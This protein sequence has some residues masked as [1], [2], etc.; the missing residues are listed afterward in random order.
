MPAGPF[1]AKALVR[2]L[3]LATLA[4][5]C[6]EGFARAM[7]DPAAEVVLQD[8]SPSS[9]DGQ[10]NDLAQV[11]V[12]LT[13][14][15]SSDS[16]PDEGATPGME[17]EQAALPE[18]KQRRPGTFVRWVLFLWT[19]LLLLSDPQLAVCQPLP[20]PAGPPPGPI[21]PALPLL[22]APQS[23]TLVAPPTFQWLPAQVLQPFNAKDQAKATAAL[24]AALVQ[25]LQVPLP[26]SNATQLLANL[27]GARVAT[28]APYSLPL[29]APNNANGTVAPTD[30]E[31]AT[32]ALFQTAR[33]IQNNVLD[34]GTGGGP[35]NS[36]SAQI[37]TQLSSIQDQLNNALALRSNSQPNTS[38]ALSNGLW[39]ALASFS[40]IASAALSTPTDLNN[41]ALVAGTASEIDETIT[42]FINLYLITELRLPAI[43]LNLERFANFSRRSEKN[44]ENSG[45]GPPSIEFERAECLNCTKSCNFE[46]NSYQY[47]TAVYGEEGTTINLLAYAYFFIKGVQLAA[48]DAAILANV[49]ASSS[50]N[51]TN[52]SNCS[53]TGGP[54]PARR[55]LQANSMELGN[56]TVGTDANATLPSGPGP[57]FP[58]P[59][60]RYTSLQ[61]QNL[62]PLLP[63]DT[64]S[65]P[66]VMNRLGINGYTPYD[67]GCTQCCFLDVNKP[68]LAAARIAVITAW[69]NAIGAG[70]FGLRVDLATQAFLETLDPVQGP[71]VLA[72]I[73]SNA[74]QYF[75]E[76]FEGATPPSPGSGD[77]GALPDLAVLQA[78]MA[79]V[80][81]AVGSS[82]APPAPALLSGIL[83]TAMQNRQASR[84][85]TNTNLTDT[86][87]YGLQILANMAAQMPSAVTVKVVTGSLNLAQQW[88]ADTGYLLRLLSN[89]VGIE[90]NQIATARASKVLLDYAN[91]QTTNSV[92]QDPDNPLCGSKKC[93]RECN[94]LNFQIQYGSVDIRLVAAQIGGVAYTLAITANFMNL[95]MDANQIINAIIAQLNTAPPAKMAANHLSGMPFGMRFYAKSAPA[96]SADSFAGLIQPMDAS[97]ASAMS[98][99]QVIALPQ[100][101]LSADTF[102]GLSIEDYGLPGVIELVKQSVRASNITDNCLPCCDIENS[103]EILDTDA[104]TLLSSQFV[105][106]GY[107]LTDVAAGI[108]IGIQAI[109][110]ISLLPTLVRAINAT[111]WA[112]ATPAM[113]SNP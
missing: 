38:D 51:S 18:Q 101:F 70:L 56:S 86:A 64:V 32:T 83:G 69:L 12:E 4:L 11:P 100:A 79:Q 71:A 67:P 97:L 106:S 61:P 36:S 62:P 80:T 109:T 90:A 99:T 54:G 52:Q 28:T 33:Y 92:Y 110:D 50:L 22:L 27:T 26:I 49:T 41:A 102:N 40:S 48:L 9:M 78:T 108:R 14:A 84:Q 76:F 107:V 75:N 30:L 95:G 7:G 112:P 66:D 96:V 42:N 24:N 77:P 45:I 73:R 81:K 98:L 87:W 53:A 39:N 1:H 8:A 59:L 3:A 44:P 91:N 74:T 111:L 5:A 20:L 29:D 105:M 21:P 43:E 16:E 88:I 60:D 93:V 17:S 68:I 65:V 57:R 37:L 47:A 85:G 63:L 2:Q 13:P 103:V 113:G 104:A 82:G 55:L 35:G 46:Q 72:G 34:P 31:A 94:H 19:T 10:V 15:T 58:A 23:L 25:M 89:A 6:S